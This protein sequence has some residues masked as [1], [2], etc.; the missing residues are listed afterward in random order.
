MDDLQSKM[1][2]LEKLRDAF[3]SF[4][5]ALT[6]ELDLKHKTTEELFSLLD[7][8]PVSG[9]KMRIISE[10]QKRGELKS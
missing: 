1:N 7:V 8:M 3:E 5:L 4:D 9:T 2:Q 6:K 10:L